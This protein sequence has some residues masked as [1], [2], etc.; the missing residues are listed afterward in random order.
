MNKEIMKNEAISR[1]QQLGLPE[2]VI[3]NF[4]KNDGIT[5]SL[6]DDQSGTQAPLD[7]EAQKAIEDT[8]AYGLPYHVIKIAMFDY[9]TYA[10]LYVSEHQDEWGMER[11]DKESSIIL[12]NVWMTCHQCAEMGSI[13]VI[14]LA[15]GLWRVG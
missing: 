13:S 7:E 2:S 1:M 5:M 11:Y 15:E 10:V 3:E 12:A 8:K 6:S 14:P 4:T 9:M